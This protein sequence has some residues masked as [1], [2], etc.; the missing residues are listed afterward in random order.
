MV[1]FSGA[2]DWCCLVLRGFV[3]LFGLFEVGCF[4]VECCWCDLAVGLRVLCL[5]CWIMMCLHGLV[6]IV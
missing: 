4:V 6:V 3:V 1:C 5:C 2:C